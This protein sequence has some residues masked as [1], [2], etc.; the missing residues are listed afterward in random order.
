MFLRD[1]GVQLSF[2]SPSDMTV[3]EYQNQPFFVLHFTRH[4]KQYLSCGERKSTSISVKDSV[5]GASQRCEKRASTSNAGFALF[6]R[7]RLI[8]GSGDEPY[9]PEAIFGKSNSYRYQRFS[10]NSVCKG[11]RLVIKATRW[12]EHE[13]VFL[14][15]LREHLDEKPLQLLLQAEEHRVRPPKAIIR[16]VPG[17]HGADSRGH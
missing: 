9:R 2:G 6:R 10:G 13:E 11:S 17:C 12:E 4:P 15:L 5:R 1:G 3:L 7:K 14:Q 16:A 8:Q